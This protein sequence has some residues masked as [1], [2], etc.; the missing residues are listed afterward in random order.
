M[1]GKTLQ[2]DVATLERQLAEQAGAAGRERGALE[3]EAA[4]LGESLAAERGQ[5]R[6]LRQQLAALTAAAEAD[7]DAAMHAQRTAQQACFVRVLRVSLFRSPP[8]SAAL[9]GASSLCSAC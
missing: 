9:L 3:A 8:S 1:R 2:G 4:R 6:A 5:A 7:R